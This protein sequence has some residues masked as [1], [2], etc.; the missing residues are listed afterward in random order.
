LFLTENNIAML[1]QLETK[2]MSSTLPVFD[3]TNVA[4]KAN[5]NSRKSSDSS[6]KESTPSY[7][8]LDLEVDLDKEKIEKLKELY[9]DRTEIELVKTFYYRRR[10]LEFGADLFYIMLDYWNKNLFKKGSNL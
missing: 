2:L 6:E 4:V 7:I 3:K 1:N 8:P 9:P 5:E 10:I